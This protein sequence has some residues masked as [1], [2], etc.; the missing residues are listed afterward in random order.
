MN[1]S[2]SFI[3][4]RPAAMALEASC[5]VDI[6]ALITPPIIGTG[7]VSPAS[8]FN[9]GRRGDGI[10]FGLITSLA[11]IA[12]VKIQKSAFEAIPFA[13]ELEGLVAGGAVAGPRARSIPLLFHLLLMSPP[14][15]VNHDRLQ[16]AQ[17]RL[18]YPRNSLHYVHLRHWP[19][20]P[21]LEGLGLNGRFLL[22]GIGLMVHGTHF[23]MGDAHWRCHYHGR[24]GL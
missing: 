20:R 18:N 8:A 5:V 16:V 4:G 21:W 15:S 14:I 22:R 1:P 12:E 9:S 11:A 24:L 10:G 2:V 7:Y 23:V 6:S 13:V 3:P 17:L 19:L